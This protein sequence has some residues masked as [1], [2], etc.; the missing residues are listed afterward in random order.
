MVR[1]FGS[2]PRNTGSTPVGA[3]ATPRLRSASTY[4]LKL[5]SASACQ[6]FFSYGVGLD[7]PGNTAGGVVETVAEGTVAE[8]TVAAG[9]LT[10]TGRSGGT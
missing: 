5:R 9:T 10:L 1:T 3:T 4:S 7:W 8:G 2:Q 6:H